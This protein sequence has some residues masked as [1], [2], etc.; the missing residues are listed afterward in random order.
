MV[1]GRSF[2]GLI[3]AIGH[4]DLLKVDVEGAEWHIL[5]DWALERVGAI[6]GEYHHTGDDAAREQFFARLQ[7]HFDLTVGPSAGFIAFC[8]SRLRLP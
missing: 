7:R 4:V 3:E 1:T 5:D 2:R 6:V 8:G